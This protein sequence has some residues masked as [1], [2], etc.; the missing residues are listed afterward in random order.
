MPGYALYLPGRPARNA[1]ALEAVGLLGLCKDSGPEFADI[2]GKGPDGGHGL[3]ATWR[4]VTDSGGLTVGEYTWKPAKADKA[5]SLPAKRFWLGT[6]LAGIAPQDIERKQ[7]FRGYGITLA[8]GH[9]WIIPPAVNLPHKHGLDD[10]G[11]PARIIADEWRAYWERSEQ[12]AVEFFHA[13]DL[14]AHGQQEAKFTLKDAWRFACE[15]LAINYRIAPEVV[16]A[17]GLLTDEGVNNIVCAA[18]DWPTMIKNGGNQK[19]TEEI[20]IPVG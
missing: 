11:E 6:P 9:K 20:T 4:K 7:Q 8:D 1:S 15:A 16:D 14:I 2:L 3:L 17:L 12:F 13:F 10:D 5:R 19:K 18:I